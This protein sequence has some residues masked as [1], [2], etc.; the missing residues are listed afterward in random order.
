MNVMRRDEALAGGKK[1]QTP[2]QLQRF[3]ICFTAI[4]SPC[5]RDNIHMEMNCSCCSMIFF[6]K[7]CRSER[8]WMGNLMIQIA[9]LSSLALASSRSPDRAHEKEKNVFNINA[10]IYKGFN[11]WMKIYT[12]MREDCTRKACMGSDSFM[13]LSLERKSRICS[14]NYRSAWHFTLCS[15]SRIRWRILSLRRKLRED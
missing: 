15:L 6:M 4:T 9:S 3:T 13:R 10:P 5:H 7:M 14:A 2:D 8:K 11:K 12:Y 1:E